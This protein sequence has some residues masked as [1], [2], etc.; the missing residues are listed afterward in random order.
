MVLLGERGVNGD[1]LGDVVLAV[2]GRE[3]DAGEGD[4]DTGVLE[5]LDHLREVGLGLLEGEA[6]E[7]VVAAE[8]YDDDTAGMAGEAREDAVDALEAVLGGVAADA[9]VDDAIHEALVVEQELEL[10]GVGVAGL[11]A[12]AGG[13][14]VAEAEDERARVV[15]WV[16]DGIGGRR[17]G[18]CGGELCGIRLR[19]GGCRR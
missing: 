19:R 8:L 5:L 10:V 4:L 16:R 7:S 11:S 3:G 1:E 17:S 15:G 14:G 18:G 2:V 9:G 13:E 6:A 12:V